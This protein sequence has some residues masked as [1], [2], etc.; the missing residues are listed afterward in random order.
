MSHL[1]TAQDLGVQQALKEAGYA[2][3]EDVQKQAEALGLLKKEAAAPANP[4]DGL[5]ALLGKR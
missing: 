5:L 4:T 1:K 3:I 2:S